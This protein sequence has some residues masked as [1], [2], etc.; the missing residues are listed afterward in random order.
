MTELIKL[1]RQKGR[2]VE[3]AQQ[4]LVIETDLGFNLGGRE[5]LPQQQQNPNNN[6]VR[7]V[8]LKRGRWRCAVLGGDEVYGVCTSV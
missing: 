6:S 3:M 7:A 8:F 4:V 5:H 2:V 1:S